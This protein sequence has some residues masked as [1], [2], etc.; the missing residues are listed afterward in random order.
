LLLLFLFLFPAAEW[1]YMMT[2]PTLCQFAQDPED[3]SRGKCIHELMVTESE[4]QRERRKSRASLDILNG[5]GVIHMRSPGDNVRSLTDVVDDKLDDKL[6]GKPLP[7]N[8]AVVNK[9]MSMAM[10]G[11]SVAGTDPHFG[12]QGSFAT[13]NPYAGVTASG[14][15]DATANEGAT[16]GTIAN[17]GLALKQGGDRADMINN[18]SNYVRQDKGEKALTE[19]GGITEGAFE[20]AFEGAGSNPFLKEEYYARQTE[21]ISADKVQLVDEIDGELQLATGKIL[22]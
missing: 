13:Q 17:G 15:A 2:D 8:P 20:G 5:N 18:L 4:K 16:N 6:D 14:G 21:D 19:G 12:Q 9:F 10:E 3:P 22:I 7:G 11:S 1:I